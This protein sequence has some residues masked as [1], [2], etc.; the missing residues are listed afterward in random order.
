MWFL[1]WPACFALFR[2]SFALESDFL[3]FCGYVFLFCLAIVAVV[4][5]Q[6]YWRGTIFVAGTL[7]CI[8]IGSYLVLSRRGYDFSDQ[9]GLIGF[10]FVPPEDTDEWRRVEWNLRQLY[11]PLIYAEYW[12][13]TGR[14]LAAEPL[15]RLS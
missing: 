5:L 13:G 4:F 14:P 10:Y 3:Y 15:W 9:Y 8:Y 11:A 12:T 2:L 1:S 6:K 7:F